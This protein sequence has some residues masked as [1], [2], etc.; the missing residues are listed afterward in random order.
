MLSSDESVSGLTPS[1]AEIQA[2][3]SEVP[4]LIDIH[5]ADG[6]VLVSDLP[7]SPDLTTQQVAAIC[8]K[9]I[10]LDDKARM[11]YVG[12]FVRNSYIDKTSRKMVN[13]FVSLPY[14]K[15]LIQAV[16]AESNSEKTQRL[17]FKWRLFEDSKKARKEGYS[18]QHPRTGRLEYL[19]ALAT[20][21]R[22][23][24]GTRFE[25]Q[26]RRLY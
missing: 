5:I 21:W 18:E 10:S 14:Q 25:I 22:E 19:S 9:I 20:C 12:L 6:T 24:S 13:Y 4:T 11:P 26:M 2:Y 17:V 7:V 8:A 3:K 15:P 23:T 16:R 1:I